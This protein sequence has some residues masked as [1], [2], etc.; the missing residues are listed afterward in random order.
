MLQFGLKMTFRPILMSL[1]FSLPMTVFF[2]IVFPHFYGALI[3]L[4]V[5][6]IFFILYYY[7]ASKFLFD[8]WE[9]DGDVIRYNDIL[10]PKR[11]ILMMMFP[12]T[13]P[14][15]TIKKS[16][17]KTISNDGDFGKLWQP[18]FIYNYTMGLGFQNS[19]MTRV[20]TPVGLV[21]T[22]KDGQVIYLMVSRDYSYD[23]KK[24]VARVEQF[25]NQFDKSQ[26]IITKNASRTIK[27]A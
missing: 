5:Y 6:L 24:T 26:V 17:I 21:L 15:K 25:L 18:S 2:W 12:H 4:S 8:Y 11:R 10:N 1:L 3:G 9:D 7:P 19:I 14:L 27:L 16:D 20:H 22:M 23:T 13:V